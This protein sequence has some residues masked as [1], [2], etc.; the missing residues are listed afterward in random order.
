MSD[1]YANDDR[2]VTKASLF[3]TMLNVDVF[4]FDYAY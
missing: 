2:C 4:S 1:R 3:P